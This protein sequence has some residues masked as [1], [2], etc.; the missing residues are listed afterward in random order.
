MQKKVITLIATILMSTTLL[1]GKTLVTVNGN[2][3]D[4]SII[5]KGYE[6]LDDTKTAELMEHLIKEELIH[7]YLLKSDIVNDPK[8]K[9]AFA[10]QKELAQEQYKKASGKNLTKEQIRN[11]KGS[12]ALMAYQQKQFQ[13]T[14][15][16]DSEVKDFYNNNEEKFNFPNS[17]EIANIITKTHKEA[18]AIIN[19]LKKAKN[20][21][22]EFI[23]I[24]KEYK[25]NGYMGWFG[26]G[27]APENLF[28]SAYKA[29]PKT[30]LKTP[31]ETKHGYHVVYLLN[32][33]AAG[34]ISFEESKENIKQ[35]LKKKKIIESLKDKID[36]LYGNAEIVY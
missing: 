11:I 35:M 9:E 32:K 25:Q 15:I 20:L 29:K 12:I 13:A 3:I 17:I 31:I 36:T 19:R 23:K 2:K 18:V 30:L 14:T 33:K 34:K 16:K 1:M 8:F 10:K 27:Q 26:E 7:A 4:D 28:N 5:P 22:E 6:K 24:A 21:N